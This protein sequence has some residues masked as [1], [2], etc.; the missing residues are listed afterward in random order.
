MMVPGLLYLLINNY[1]P[2]FGLFVA[3]KDINYSEGL[4]KGIIN[5]P[6]AGLK[7]FEFL[8]ASKDAWTITRNTV[9][10]NAVFI[11]MNTICAIGLAILLKEI[12]RKLFSRFFQSVMLLPNFISIIVVSYLV[13]G[14]FSHESGFMNKTIL[15][16]L[17][18]DPLMWYMTPDKWPLILILVNFWKNAGMLTIIYYSAVLGINPAY[19]EA[20]EIDGA[21]R[22]K[23]IWSITLPSITP[24]IIM[25]MLLSVGRIFYSDFG[26]FYQVPMNSGLLY[27]MTSTIDTYVYRSLLQIGDVSMAAAAG[28]FQS[29]VGFALV[30]FSNSVVRKLSR[31]NALF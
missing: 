7:H 30:L 26:L 16:L 13:F 14:L 31:E 15:P 24:V 9:L 6:W 3:F 17:G 10:Y 25:M 23:Q 20:A 29:I 5:G 21:G 11:A 19:Y 8:F 27:D 2:L 28:F 4:L 18:Q 22:L 12:G 1:L